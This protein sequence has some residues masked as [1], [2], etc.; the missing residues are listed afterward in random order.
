MLIPLYIP[1][2]LKNTTVDLSEVANFEIN[3]KI[4]KIEMDGDV[5]RL[6]DYKTGNAKNAAKKM[7]GPTEDD[8]LGGD[9]WR[10]AVFYYILL[11]NCGLELTDKKVLIKYVFVEN[12]KNEKGF[13]ETPDIEVTEDEVNSV[14]EQVKGMLKQLESGDFNCGCGNVA[15]DRS[16]GIYPCD[17]CIQASLNFTPSYDN[18]KAVEVATF[19]Q[20]INNFKSLSVSKLNRFINCPKSFYFD[21]ILQLTTAASLTG[22]KK[23]HAT[24]EKTKHIPTGAVFGTVIHETMEKI[25][26]D[27]LDF[28][29]AMKVFNKSLAIHESEIIDTM[30][31]E[32][33]KKYGYHLLDNLF[34]EYIPN[35]LKGDNINLEKEIYVT[36]NGKY[37]INGIID[38]LEFDGDTIR[39]VDYKTGST[40]RGVEELEVGKDYW[41]QAAY[42][43][44]LLQT[45]LDIDTTNKKIETQYIFLDDEHSENSYSIHTITIGEED[46][47]TVEAQIHEMYHQIKAADFT[48]SCHRDDCDFCRLG[49]FVDFENLKNKN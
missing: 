6:I 26:R 18:T 43:N 38:K 3:G 24:R 23:E 1:K 40:Q 20:T 7:I 15:S 37:P 41:R 16:K 46:T 34:I 32:E 27:N 10:Q 25:Y 35:S 17:S 5:I 47:K 8:L 12:A 42:Y 9:Y 48:H 21:D 19:E 39:V 45:S 28:E 4:D 14:L 22:G 36:L 29:N 49:E 33:I 11:T 2:T 13:S 30:P 44:L 31:A